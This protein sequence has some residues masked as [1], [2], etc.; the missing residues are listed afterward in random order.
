MDGLATVFGLEV[1]EPLPED[2]VPLEAI[3]TVKCLDDEG[4]TAMHHTATP[5][6]NTW[7]AIGMVRW[8]QLILDEGLLGNG[9]DE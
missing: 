3:V 7:E 1:L 5:K 8:T 9:E 4:K 6:L 2:W